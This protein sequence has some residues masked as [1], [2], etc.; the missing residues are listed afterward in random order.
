MH[1]RQ[2]LLLLLSLQVT[3]CVDVDGVTVDIV[4]PGQIVDGMTVSCSFDRSY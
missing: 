4:F 1:R 2:L 3:L